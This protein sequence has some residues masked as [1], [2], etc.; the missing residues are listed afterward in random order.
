MRSIVPCFE[1]DAT[2]SLSCDQSA[3]VLSTSP[4]VLELTGLPLSERYELEWTRKSSAK[5]LSAVSRQSPRSEPEWSLTPLNWFVKALDSASEMETEL[6]VVEPGQLPECSSPDA[7]MLSRPVQRDNRS[8]RAI[9][10]LVYR[11]SD[12]ES[13]V[14]DPSAAAVTNVLDS[15]SIWKEHILGSITHSLPTTGH[16]DA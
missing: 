3:A 1:E 10:R 16:P 12:A 7:M 13:R 8:S 4:G 14:R 2:P 15:Y 6:E 5:M 11:A 9:S